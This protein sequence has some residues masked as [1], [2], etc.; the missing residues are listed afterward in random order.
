MSASRLLPAHVLHHDEV[1]AVG[2]LDLVNGDDVGMVERGGGLRF[3]HE[4]PAAALVRHPVGGSTLMAT[5]RFSR[6]SRAR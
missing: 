5:S 3:L 6:G 1:A 4:P 2:R